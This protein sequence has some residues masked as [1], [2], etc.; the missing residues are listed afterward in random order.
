M[1]Q[2]SFDVVLPSVSQDRFMKS[3]YDSYDKQ[4]KGA[5]RKKI[6]EKNI[7]IYIYIYIYVLLH[8]FFFF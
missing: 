4:K 3:L 2:E 5:L 6:E 7:Y 8:S 1:D